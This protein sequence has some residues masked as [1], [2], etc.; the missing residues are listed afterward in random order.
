MNRNMGEDDKEPR[1]VEPLES[2]S[3]P[4][5]VQ[6]PV[7]LCPDTW[8]CGYGRSSLAVTD[9]TG[10]PILFLDPSESEYEVA[11]DPED[12]KALIALINNNKQ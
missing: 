1:Y 12:A 6:L 3:K 5:T 2:W 10:R 8:Y 4:G 9:A 7:S 11:C